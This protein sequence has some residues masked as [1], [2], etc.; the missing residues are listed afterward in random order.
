LRFLFP[1][2]DGFGGAI[3]FVLSAGFSGADEGVGKSALMGR[4]PAKGG[5]V[6]AGRWLAGQL[7]F[8]VL[9]D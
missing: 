8:E 7:T 9:V 4:F 3:S 6:Q 1:S 5:T 2:V